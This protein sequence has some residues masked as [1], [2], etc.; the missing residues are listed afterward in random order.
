MT[1][2][3]VGII[4]APQWVSSVWSLFSSEPLIPWLTAHNIPHFAFSPWFIT[5]PL[6]LGMFGIILWPQLKGFFQPTPTF[7][8]N[9]N[10]LPKNILEAEWCLAY[11]PNSQV[12]PKTTFLSDAPVPGSVAIA[13]PADHAFDYRLPA[14]VHP[15]NKVVFSAKYLNGTMIFL[16]FILKPKSGTESYWRWVKIS[17]GDRQSFRTPGYEVHEWTLKVRGEPLGNGWR[18]FDLSLR[19]VARDTWEKDGLSFEGVAVFRV[20]GTLEIS[21]IRFYEKT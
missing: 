14:S 9:F 16:Q 18:R 11:P 12:K 4:G 7:E 3:S 13:A 17:V 19:D 8:I 6:G 5:V 20:R 2:I 1:A 21:P 10:H 15:S